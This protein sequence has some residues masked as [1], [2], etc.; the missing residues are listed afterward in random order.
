MSYVA[1][2]GPC[3]LSEF[4]TLTGAQKFNPFAAKQVKSKFQPNIQISQAERFDLNDHI[5]GFRP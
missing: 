4:L 5:L 1:V 3:R 2:S